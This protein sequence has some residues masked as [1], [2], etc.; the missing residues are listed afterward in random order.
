MGIGKLSLDLAKQCVNGSGQKPLFLDFP[1][2]IFPR[3]FGRGRGNCLKTPRCLAP[4]GA[5]AGA[6]SGPV[7][8]RQTVG[9]A[10]PGAAR[11]WKKLAK[12]P[13][14]LTRPK[15]CFGTSPLARCAPS[16]GLAGPRIALLRND[17]CTCAFFFDSRLSFFLKTLFPRFGE[18]PLGGQASGGFFR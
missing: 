11:G 12:T 15:L 10:P 5:I 6:P 13:R 1:L 9:E 18:G 17:G 3:A 14:R 2:C 7:C 16:G 8:Q 4:Q